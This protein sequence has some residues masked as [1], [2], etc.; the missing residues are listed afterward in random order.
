[1]EA[2]KT[3]RTNPNRWHVI[4]DICDAAD[5]LFPIPNPKPQVRPQEAMAAAAPRRRKT[6]VGA[7]F[8]YHPIAD[9]ASS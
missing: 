3:N 7:F 4:E 2:R 5:E 1:M 8:D 6:A 9:V